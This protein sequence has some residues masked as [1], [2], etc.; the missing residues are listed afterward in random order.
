[1][2][3]TYDFKGQVA[4]VTG[5][6]SGMGLSTAQAFADAGAAV[7]LADVN[8]NAVEAAAADLS[9]AGHQV[10]GITCDVADESRLRPWSTASSGP[11]VD[12]T[13]LSTTPASRSPRAT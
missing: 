3:P 1:M 4:L 8:A 13:W 7:V 9:A 12:S 5:A 6:A 11:S 10:L 2:N